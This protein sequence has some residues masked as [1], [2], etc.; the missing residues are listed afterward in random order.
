MKGPYE[1][2]KY[3][4]RRIWECPNCHHR[5]RT[6]GSMT[7]MVCKCQSNEPPGKRVV[8]RLVEEG[9][10][11]YVPGAGTLPADPEND[12]LTSGEAAE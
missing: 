9:F 12:A 7:S 10:K 8:M 3:D 11:Q 1:R 5:E 4:G 6:L 2:L